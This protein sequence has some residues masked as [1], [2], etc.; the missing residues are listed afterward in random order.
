MRSREMG[1]PTVE[2]GTGSNR[3]AEGSD[4]GTGGRRPVTSPHGPGLRRRRPM[5]LPAVALGLALLILCP[6]C[7]TGGAP[8]TRSAGDVRTAPYAVVGPAPAGP[9]ATGATQASATG[10]TFRWL[11]WNQTTDPPARSYATMG[12]DPAEGGVVLF[13]GLS[14]TDQFLNDTW[15]FRNSS[16]TELCSGRTQAPTCGTSPPPVEWGA[17]AYDPTSGQLLLFGGIQAGT[18]ADSNQ[19]W[20]LTNGSWQNLTAA[21]APPPLDGPSM[22]Y[23]PATGSMILAAGSGGTWSFAHDRWSKLTLAGSAPTPSGFLFEN[24]N[25][26]GVLL[27]DDSNRTT[28]EFSGGTWTEVNPA[29]EP[30]AGTFLAGADNTEFGYGLVVLASSRGNSS[31]WEFSNGTWVNVTSTVG[32]GPGGFPRPA[33]AYDSTQGYTVYLEQL[34]SL[35]AANETWV[36]HDP[37]RLTLVSTR[38]VADVGQNLT[39]SVSTI[40]GMGPYTLH[41]SS[42]PVGCVAPPVRNGTLTVPCTTTQAGEFLFNVSATD[43]LGTALSVQLPLAVSPPLAVSASVS[44]SPTTVGVPVSLQGATSGGAPP[45]RTSWT[46]TPGNG[47]PN[48]TLPGTRA[49]YT[50]GAVGSYV[51]TFEATDAAGATQNRTAEIDVYSA[52]ALAAGANRTVVDAGMSVGFSAN[53]S[54]GLSPLSY[55]WEFG[56]GDTASTSAPR[57]TYADAGRYNATVWANDSAAS[58]AV[59]RV[60][61]QVNP[62]LAVTAQANVT[63]VGLYAPVR[64]SDRVT[65]GT[66]PYTY[67]WD[68]GNAGSAT[69]ATAVHAFTRL[70]NQTVS[71]VVNDSVGASQSSQIQIQVVAAPT[72]VPPGNATTPAGAPEWEYA[73]G[74][75][76]AVV[77]VAGILVAAV[78]LRKRRP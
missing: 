30:G 39:Y 7:G 8:P 36:L 57:H 13:G 28:W 41:L 6:A 18:L 52:I 78:V 29:Q 4:F 38:S 20:A 17:M 10:G 68:F 43:Q 23:D 16:W 46:I 56:D 67:W 54:G 2:G 72:T 24:A 64:F 32:S 58:R 50:F 19:T 73:V 45:V 77:V 33:M 76:A 75:G 21:V 71:L 37:M 44:P 25:G 49:N 12:D 11:F 9:L 3:V 22:A 61:I 55:A 65:G 14:S 51:A 62:M 69:T 74:A 63:R 59:A 5:L 42:L 40:G 1:S 35:R 15:V 26:S 60:A 53:A 27:W 47:T 70:G 66:G 31:T 34:A 48:A